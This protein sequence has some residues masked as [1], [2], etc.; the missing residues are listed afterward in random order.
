MLGSFDLTHAKSIDDAVELKAKFGGEAAFYAGGTELL[1]VL[2]E[3]L[4]LY[5]QLISLR[6]LPDMNQIE[7]D[8]EQGVLRIGA[9]TT[10]AE[11]AKSPLI[12][13]Y[14]A[15]FAELEDHIGNIRIRTSGTIGGNLAFAEP[16]SDPGAYLVAANA[17]VYVRSLSD[18]RII[19]M[20]DFW[21]GPFETSLDPGEVIMHIDVPILETHNGAAYKKFSVAEFPMAGVAVIVKL[22][23]KKEK[24]A[25]CRLVVAATNPIPTRLTSAE[26]LLVGESLEIVNREVEWWVDA[27]RP[28]MDAVDDY[29]GS[30]EY[31][32]HVVGVLLREAVQEAINRA[33]E[34]N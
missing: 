5:E 26:D 22:D 31:K 14:Q 17:S 18:S 24:L 30:A 6:R 10:H 9:L 23:E 12:R 32:N 4:I 13:R 21:R 28:E 20:S 8:E 33:R 25:E 34:V 7:F 3:G 29:D 11:I 1:Q 27:A 2:K 16:R 19:P 15:A